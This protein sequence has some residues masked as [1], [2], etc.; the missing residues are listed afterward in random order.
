MSD[1][2][3]TA[4]WTAYLRI[5]LKCLMAYSIA[6]FCVA[7][8]FFRHLMPSKSLDVLMIALYLAVIMLCAKHLKQRLPLP[9]LIILMPLIP[10]VPIILVILVFIPLFQYL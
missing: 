4:H 2:V 8:Y 1:K 6:S 5:I 7:M 3:V 9:L 10:L